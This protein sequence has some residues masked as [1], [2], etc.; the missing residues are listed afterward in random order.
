M[1]AH[2]VDGI[3]IQ[4]DAGTAQIPEDRT[5]DLEKRMKSRIH[6]VMRKYRTKETK[7][8]L[9]SRSNPNPANIYSQL[10]GMMTA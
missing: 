1:R 8:L 5:K 3:Y 7:R 2:A 4:P 10:F 9:A 6:K